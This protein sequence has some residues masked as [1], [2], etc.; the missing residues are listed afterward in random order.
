MKATFLLV[1]TN[2][3]VMAVLAVIFELFGINQ[4]L[5]QQGSSS[6][7]FLAFACI[8]GFAGSFIS[9]MLSKGMAKKQMRVQLIENP[10]NDTER[11]LVE[12]VR[13]QAEKAGVGMPEVGIFQQPSP[14]AFATGA[15]KN[16]ALVAVS[17]GLLQHMNADEVEAVLGHEMAHVSNGDMV[18]SALIQGT[19]NSFVIVF[20]QIIASMLSRGSNGRSSRAGYFA[21]YMVLQMVLGFLG[22]MIVMWHSRHREFK[23]DAGGAH[24]AGKHK[25]IAAL[26]ALQRAQQQ[27]AEGAM[28]KDFKA[29]GIVPMNGL[30]ATHPPLEKRIAAL[31]S[32]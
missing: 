14:N 22:S 26:E 16:K 19:I 17:T 9:L 18:T 11:W 10:S 2:L 20:A 27:G 8:Y 32:L 29:F 13:R 30:F 3:G 7:S 21:T 1:A 6:W 5:A 15:N 28:A 12:T 31:K 25:M 4:A 24:F 23:A